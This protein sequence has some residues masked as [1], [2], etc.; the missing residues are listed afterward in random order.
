M[1]LEKIRDRMPVRLAQHVLHFESAIASAVR[2]FAAETPA[3]ALVLDAGAGQG[4][5]RGYFVRQR[6]YGL[7]MGVGDASWDYSRLDVLGDLQKLPFATGVFDAA[8]NIVTLEH[9]RE[10]ARVLEEIAR[11]LKPGGRLL[12]VAPQEWE[13]HQQPHDYFRYTR[14]GLQY[15]LERAGFQEICLEPVGGF[16]RLLSRRLLNALQ[17]FPG[18]WMLLA[19]VVFT[20]PALLLPLL[21]GLD[22]RKNFTLG[23]ICFARKLS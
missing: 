20:P 11:V 1:T 19:A 16:F 3:G 18:P 21:D 17:F 23:Y 6:Y 12:L 5:H 22:R 15:L 8:I 7:D 13:E 2:A 14:Y 10:P 9:V 4:T